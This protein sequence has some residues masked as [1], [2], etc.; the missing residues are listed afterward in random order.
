LARAAFGGLLAALIVIG[1][2]GTGAYAADDDEE[3]F[4][5]KFLKGIM[6]SLG[7]RST[8]DPGI[9]YRERPPLVIPPAR[10]LPPPESAAAAARGAAWPNDPDVLR[11]KQ[12]KAD[13]KKPYKTVEEESLPETPDQLMSR[14]TAS[15]PSHRPTGDSKDPTAPSTM[16]E[17]GA[18]SMFTWGGLF[19][20]KEEYGTFAGEPPRASLIEPPK[21][22]R[23]PS[24]DQPYG[25]G[26][27]KWTAP[28]VNPMDT[29]AMRG[30]Q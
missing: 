1:S 17:L 28:T 29:D 4:D 22:Y 21:G 9:E 19:G 26:K 25:V 11:A 7:L 13:K 27:E 5:T 20:Q 18:K 2:A 8:D 16:S 10:S 3:A 6:R 24:P 30:T 15:R 23:T 14:G 12:A